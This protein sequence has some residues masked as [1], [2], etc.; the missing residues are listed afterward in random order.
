MWILSGIG[1]TNSSRVALNGVELKLVEQESKL[2]SMD[3]K[4]I[5]VEQLR[6]NDS[7]QLLL[8]PLAPATIAFVELADIGEVVG[9]PSLSTALY[10][11]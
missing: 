1:G 8:P 11:D 6:M 3:G 5:E 7:M 9:C 10:D 4:L 2:P